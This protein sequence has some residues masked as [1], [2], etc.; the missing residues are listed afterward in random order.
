MTGMV[1]SRGMTLSFDECVWVFRFSS[2]AFIKVE[3]SKNKRP[4]STMRLQTKIISIKI[5]DLID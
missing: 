5:G 1:L 2:E 4:S 3:I